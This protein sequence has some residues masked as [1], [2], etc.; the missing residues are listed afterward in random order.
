MEHYEINA[1]LSQG[2]LLEANLKRLISPYNGLFMGP[3]IIGF[4]VDMFLAGIMLK[5]LISWGSYAKEDRWFIRIIIL[6]CSIFGIIGTVFNLAFCFDIFVY[7]YG[8]Y[9]TL[10]EPQWSSC[11][12]I[13]S[14]LTSAG[15]QLFY[16]DRAYKLSGK[17]KILALT[18][19]SAILLSVIGG[20][21]SKITSVSNAD[22]SKAKLATTFIY[23]LT[24]GSMIADFIIT[25][26]ILY[27]LSR[28]KSGFAV[29]DKIVNRL[30][31]ISAESQLPPTLLS[32]AFLVIF[33]YKTTKAN[34]N[35]NEVI[36]DVTSN[37]TIFFMMIIPKTY[38]VGFVAV[39]NARTGLK[40]VYSATHEL[41]SKT[42]KTNDFQMTSR[43]GIE[44]GIQITTETYTHSEGYTNSPTKPFSSA[45]SIAK[46]S[47]AIEVEDDAS[48]RN[49]NLRGN[50]SEAG[51][52][53]GLTWTE[54]D[55]SR[56]GSI[57][58]SFGS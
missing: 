47:S 49:M 8:K 18:I 33:A 35:P 5:Q 29:T 15:V 11:L 51:S 57:R 58:T 24:A 54:N 9:S 38:I 17:N 53:T 28:S 13:I 4:I 43:R 26:A 39:L 40:A 45:L 20:I 31:A 21:G 27:L 7:N 16:T 55:E 48:V 56:V 32:I 12:G 52:R 30:L 3:I 37:L 22:V 34:A 36:I 42:H 44:S 14:S 1:T 10:T 46:E 2:D 23:L 25:A 50:G 6:W 19:S 41:V